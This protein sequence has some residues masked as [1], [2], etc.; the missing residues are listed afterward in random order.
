MKAMLSWFQ[1]SGG[2]KSSNRIPLSPAISMVSAKRHRHTL[3]APVSQ[4]ALPV[5]PET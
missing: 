1:V 5:K 2:R 3:F 4:A